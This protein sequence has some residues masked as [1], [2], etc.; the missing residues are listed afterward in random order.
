[1]YMQR[2]D[3]APASLHSTYLFTQAADGDPGLLPAHHKVYIY[4]L[5]EKDG[6]ALSYGSI[7]SKMQAPTSSFQ[8]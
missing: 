2:V 1:M 5:K 8:Q 4:I 7:R 6:G 3:P